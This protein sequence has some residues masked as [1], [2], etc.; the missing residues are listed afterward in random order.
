MAA[1]LKR[2]VD[3]QPEST[4]PYERY[5]ATL[6]KVDQIDDANAAIAK[7]LEEGRRPGKLPPDAASRLQAAINRALGRGYDLYTNR[8]DERWLDPLADT[9]RFF[10][11]SE[12]GAQYADMIMNDGNFQRSDQCRQLRGEF[13]PIL[14][15]E[16]TTLKQP[17]LDRLVNWVHAGEPAV[18]AEVWRQMATRLVTRWETTADVEAKHQLGQTVARIYSWL[19]ADELLAFYRRELNDGPEKYRTTYA[20][21]L[22]SLLLTQPWTEAHEDEAFGLLE[23]ISS[24]KTPAM[25]LADEVRASTN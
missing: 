9:V 25:Q 21:Q 1:Y 2:W 6:L 11:R 8:L 12:T 18:E 17:V 19:P 4:N 14:Q 23:K 3:L 22:F 24:A 13:L 15:E 7:W 20:Q 10:Y 5:L 16:L